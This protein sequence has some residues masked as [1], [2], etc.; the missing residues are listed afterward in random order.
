VTRAI[1]R[2]R[3]N[4]VGDVLQDLVRVDDVELAV[5]ERQVVHV[6]D[7]EPKVVAVAPG[8]FG[9]GESEGLSGLFQG[10]DVSYPIGQ[11]EGDRARPGSHVEQAL[12]CPQVRQQVGRGVV[13][14]APP[15][16]AQY[17]LVVA[18]GVDRALAPKPRR[19]RPTPVSGTLQRS[20][21]DTRLP[22][23]RP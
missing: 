20:S 21:G 18:V 17:R 9:P 4:R 10:G 3:C 23:P 19:H 11:V 22:R 15:M 2:K 5:V 16:R 12:G 14:G 7:H 13:R 6:A 8:G 1:W